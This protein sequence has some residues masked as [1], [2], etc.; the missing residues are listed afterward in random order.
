LSAACRRT[1]GPFF[2]DGYPVGFFQGKLKPVATA[3]GQLRAQGLGKGDLALR[4]DFCLKR[5]HSLQITRF[6]RKSKSFVFPSHSEMDQVFHLTV[7]GLAAAAILPVAEAVG[8]VVFGKDI[9]LVF[10]PHVDQEEIIVASVIAG[11]ASM[12]EAGANEI[13]QLQLDGLDGLEEVG[14][15]FLLAVTDSGRGDEWFGCRHWIPL[16]EF[17]FILPA[18][19]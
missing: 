2:S 19:V 15:E 1:W 4:G 13:G 6:C 18:R 17:P 12:A 7:L 11:M 8:E 14:R 9:G 10:V 3:Y 5:R 16:V